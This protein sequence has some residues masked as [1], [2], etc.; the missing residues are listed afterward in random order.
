MP[1]LRISQQYII[2]AMQS[3]GVRGALKQVADG[4]A[5]YVDDLGSREGV[6]MNPTVTEGTRPKGR[7]YARVESD[8]VGQEWGDRK[9]ERHRVMGRAAEGYRS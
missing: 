3:A 6:D 9:S 4:L 1:K 8:Q 2:D 7:P 5:G